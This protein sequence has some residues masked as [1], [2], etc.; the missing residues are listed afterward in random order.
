MNYKKA[1]CKDLDYKNLN[2]LYIDY[3]KKI[4]TLFEK[5][6]NKI[7]KNKIEN[8]FKNTKKIN[9]APL[10]INKPILESINSFDNLNEEDK[11]RTIKIQANSYTHLLSKIYKKW[12]YIIT[13]DITYKDG[14][15]NW[16]IY[17]YISNI[18]TDIDVPIGGYKGIYP[19]IYIFMD[20]ECY[21]FR[22]IHPVYK[23]IDH[24][25]KL[26]RIIN[27]EELDKVNYKAY[28]SIFNAR[29]LV[30]CG[31]SGK[32]VYHATTIKENDPDHYYLF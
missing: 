15:M 26:H 6:K 1:L 3:D 28:C 19:K 8:E 27:F 22:Q 5:N 31:M 12:K 13:K 7:N 11:L 18:Y 25:E 32:Y 21:F 23:E 24:S 14:T 10:V 30:Y 9:N 17:H 2:Y 16:N 20:L 29:T 4:E